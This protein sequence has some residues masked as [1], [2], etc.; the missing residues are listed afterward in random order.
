MTTAISN[1]V[2][3]IT[4]NIRAFSS[5]SKP[6]EHRLMIES[7]GTVRVYDE[8]AGHYTTC[9]AISKPMQKRLYNQARQT[10]PYA[11]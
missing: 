2:W 3:H 10:P 8:M 4:R 5:E 11:K 9:H 6:V 1:H 7:D